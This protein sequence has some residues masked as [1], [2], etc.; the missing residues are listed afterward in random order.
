MKIKAKLNNY[1]KTYRIEVNGQ[2]FIYPSHIKIKLDYPIERVW[3]G[4]TD[5]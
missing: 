2:N 3:M 5:N 4:L 1:L